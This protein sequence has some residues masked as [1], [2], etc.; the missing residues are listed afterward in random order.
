MIVQRNVE[1]FVHSVELAV[2]VKLFKI[3]HV[4]LVELILKSTPMKT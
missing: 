2:E 4:E 3:N 1:H